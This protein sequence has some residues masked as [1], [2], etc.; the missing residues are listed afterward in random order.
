MGFA[1][2]FSAYVSLGKLYAKLMV[3]FLETFGFIGGNKDGRRN[4]DGSLSIEVVELHNIHLITIAIVESEQYETPKLT[5]VNSEK[6]I[7]LVM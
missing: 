6:S 1:A 3:W 2:N 4:D 5:L 7:E